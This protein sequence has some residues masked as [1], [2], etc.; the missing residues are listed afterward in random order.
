[1]AK[2]VVITFGKGEGKKHSVRVKPIEVEVTPAEDK[3]TVTLESDGLGD[4]YV[5]RDIMDALGLDDSD[6]IKMTIERA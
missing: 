3:P 2:T 6:K 5:S 4:F 1:M